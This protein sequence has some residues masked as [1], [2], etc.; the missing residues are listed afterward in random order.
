MP[1]KSEFRPAFERLRKQH[2]II[3]TD[4][5]SPEEWPDNHRGIFEA[6]E[7]LRQFKYSTY[8]TAEE[9]EDTFDSKS[10]AKE[11]ARK[12][13]EKTKD[14]VSR[15]EATWRFACEPLVFSRLTSEI[16]W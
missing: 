2:G 9:S 1:I 16:A 4:A 15:N 12:L 7:K 6:I 8:A 13:S 3:F 5:L 14:C 10:K 11:H